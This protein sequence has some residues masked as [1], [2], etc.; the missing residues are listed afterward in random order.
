MRASAT[1]SAWSVAAS[2]DSPLLDESQSIDDAARNRFET[3][4]ACADE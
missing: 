1:C 3:S 2:N 4:H